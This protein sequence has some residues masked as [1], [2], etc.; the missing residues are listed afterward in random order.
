[1][2]D[3]TTGGAVHFLS[4]T[5]QQTEGHKEIQTNGLADRWR[6]RETDNEIQGHSVSVC[7]CPSVSLCPSVSAHT[8]TSNETHRER[9]T[10]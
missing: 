7:V 6:E 2:A 5:D 8:L 10:N 9:E 4:H 3:I 1:M